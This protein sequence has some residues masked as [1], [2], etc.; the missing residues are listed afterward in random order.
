MGSFFGMRAWRRGPGHIDE[1][2]EYVD[3]KPYSRPKAAQG[4]SE[5]FVDLDRIAREPVE[6]EDLESAPAGREMSF[7]AAV[8]PVVSPAIMADS[9]G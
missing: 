3:I 6:L 4:V 8:R 9:I 5:E 7:F 1:R 2:H